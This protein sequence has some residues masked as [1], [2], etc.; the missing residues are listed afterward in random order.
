MRTKRLSP[1]GDGESSDK[2]SDFGPTELIEIDVEHY[3]KL[4]IIVTLW[5]IGSPREFFEDFIESMWTQLDECVK[6]DL[7]LEDFRN[8]AES[9]LKRD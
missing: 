1:T 7:V 9:L 6:P 2:P 4:L 5:K 8:I 3:E